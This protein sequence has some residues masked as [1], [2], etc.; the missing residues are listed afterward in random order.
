MSTNLKTFVLF[1]KMTIV[2]LAHIFLN[3]YPFVMKM[4]PIESSS[5]QLSTRTIFIKNGSIL[6]KLWTN[7]RDVILG[8][9]D[10]LS[11]FSRKMRSNF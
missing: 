4:V 3:T 7:P 10:R 8:Q 9:N 2:G 1:P 11:I 6:R 5:S